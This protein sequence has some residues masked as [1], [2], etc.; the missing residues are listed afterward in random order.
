MEKML[1]ESPEQPNLRDVITS[2]ERLTI[3]NLVGSTTYMFFEV[4]QLDSSFFRK[5][6]DLWVCDPAFKAANEFI[7]YIQVTNDVAERGIAR[8][9]KYV[10][11]ITEAPEEHVSSLQLIEMNCR[12]YPLK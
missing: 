5:D 4:L 10:N 12:D 1:Q 3:E 6:P 7:R 2:Q 8:I 9:T 11:S